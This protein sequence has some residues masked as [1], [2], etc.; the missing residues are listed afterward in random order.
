[1]F[2]PNDRRPTADS[3]NC[4]VIGSGPAGMS[5]AL[6][7]EKAGRRALVLESEAGNGDI[8][9]SV[10]YGH[11]PGEYWNAHWIRALGGTSNA[12]AGWVA[13]LRAIEFDHPTVGV[14]WPITRDELV[15][16]YRRAAPIIDRR[17]VIADFQR[18]VLPRWVYRPFSVADPTRFGEGYRETVTKSTMLDVAL[19]YSVVGFDATAS[20]SSITAL[21][22]WDH[23]AQAGFT[24]PIRPEQSVVV[25]AGG[26]GN[27]QLLLQPRADGS[28]PVGNESGHVGKFL[29]EHPHV[30]DAG[31]C[32]TDLEFIKY[33]PPG[34]FGRAADAVVLDDATETTHGLFGCSLE[35][36]HRMPDNDLVTHLS[37][38]GRHFQRYKITVRSEMLPTASNRV[39]LT[40]E[41]S[42]SGLYRLAARCVLCADDL[43]NVER[44]IRLLGDSLM[45]LGRGRVR[46]NNDA[47]Y[48][49]VRGGGHTMGTTR[50]GRSTSD[51]VVDRDCR[52]HG[53]NNFFIAGSS[54]FPTG[55]YANP[56]FTIVA[57]AVRLA[58]EI[59]KR[60]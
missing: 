53:Y 44:T 49:E 4:I 28:A 40:A 46:V 26:M 11:F 7:L 31:E 41:R 35:I 21:Q 43:R 15:P 2:L 54:V 1:M 59:A 13:T 25:A 39:Y 30:Y 33:A 18:D 32:I 36:R 37:A 34:S 45:T 50:M 3:Y 5:V 14:R 24:L 19:G 27:T 6:E 17:P 20:R 51:S 29:M 56:T 9:M 38:A 12:W 42:K 23:R 52:V 16:Y 55:G 60:G 57:F 8:A 58:E 10:G 48:R 22:C 47:I